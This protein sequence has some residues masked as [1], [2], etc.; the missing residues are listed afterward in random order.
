[1]YIPAAFK[2]DDLHSQWQ[3][4]DQCRLALLVTDGE[5]GLQ[6]THL[7]LLL[8]R[9]QGPHGTLYGHLAKAN[10]QGRELT[11]E[12]EVM[13]VFAGHDAYVSPSLYPSK[14]E[15]GKAVPTWNYL[16]VHVWGRPQLMTERAD[17]RQLVGALS[18]RHEA[19]RAAPWSIDDAPADYID[20]M[21]GAITG[22]AL[23]I[24]RLLGKRK[25]SQNRS[26]ADIQGVRDG[27]AASQDPHDQHIA[28]LMS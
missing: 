21:L 28:R 3:Q 20:K 7:P 18:E 10:P 19:G 17:L 16:A 9:D 25:L 14:A 11:G 13:L 6:A 24:E 26:A 15:H 12:R 23:P 27:L 2:D 4:I 1:M 22:F 5:S 8:R